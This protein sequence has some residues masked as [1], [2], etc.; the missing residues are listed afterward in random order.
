MK[1]LHVLNLG[2]GVQS[3]ALYLMFM[4]GEIKPCIDAAIFADTGDEPGA[5]Y[6]HLEWL[7]S[8][9]GPQILTGNAGTLSENLM[10]G[11]NSYG[12][13]FASIPAYTLGPEG[14]KG[15]TKRQCSKE[16]KVEVV[17]RIIRRELC[18]A[19]PGRGPRGF[20]VHQYYGISFDEGGR[21]RRIAA[22]PR[23]R[24]LKVHFPLVERFITRANC[25]D[26]LHDKV[27]HETPR[28]ACWHCPYHTDHQWDRQKREDPESW[29]KAVALDRALREPGRI[30]NRGMKHKLFLHNSCVPLDLVQLDTRPNPRAAQ[31]SINFAAECLGVC[32][33]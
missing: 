20:L 25:L 7:K 5:V 12:Q 31:L 3:T 1:E 10:R 23:A 2:A 17:E 33:V 6:R 24:Y 9:G 11:E 13:R 16:Y 15:I 14:T 32:G 29:A 22:A 18:G 28:S 19:P 21:A 4:R 26:Y 8:L 30:A 27:P